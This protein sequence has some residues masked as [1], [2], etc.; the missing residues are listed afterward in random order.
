MSDPLIA[1]LLAS[2]AAWFARTYSPGAL[3]VA[4]RVAEAF[5]RR[6]RGEDPDVIP[7]V[8]ID[9]AELDGEGRM[10]AARLLLRLGLAESM[11]KARELIRQGAVSVSYPGEEN[12]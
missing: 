3:A 6:S 10:P 2:T 1:D 12:P 9:R 8:T 11:T 7:E 4:D 5:R